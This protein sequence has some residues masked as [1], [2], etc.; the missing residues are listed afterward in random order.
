[1][2]QLSIFA[3]FLFVSS[4]IFAQLSVTTM[5]IYNIQSERATCAFTVQG[6]EKIDQK[7]VTWS[8]GHNP[9]INYYK[10]QAPDK[11]TNNCA[12]IFSGLKYL[13]LYYVRAYAMK[14]N[15]DVIYGN[16]ISF[17]TIAKPANNEKT[18]NQ[19]TGK[20][21]EQKSDDIK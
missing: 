9:T 16:E 14:Q 4:G 5:K 21:V 19:K 7:G 15:G 11:P 1:M 3:I 2:K 17:T 10:S 12:A 8:Q 6:N 13:T 20:K 18:G